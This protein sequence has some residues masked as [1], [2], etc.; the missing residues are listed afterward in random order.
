MGEKQMRSSLTSLDSQASQKPSRLLLSGLKK[1]M[2]NR[3]CAHTECSTK[4][5]KRPSLILLDYHGCAAPSARW[6]HQRHVN[7]FI[8]ELSQTFNGHNM[9]QHVTTCHNMLRRCTSPNALPSIIRQCMAPTDPPANSKPWKMNK[10]CWQHL[11]SI[12]W[13]L[14]MH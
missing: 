11:A 10:F 3:I 1:S 2:R 4:I 9:S 8:A 6:R 12:L 13:Y 5:I 14:V 7:Y